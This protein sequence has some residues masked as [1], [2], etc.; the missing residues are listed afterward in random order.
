MQ[1]FVHARIYPG[2]DDDL[3]GWLEDQP[4]GGRSEAIR[5]LMRDGMKMRQLETNLARM[6]RDAVTET[7]ANLP[8]ASEPLGSTASG[9]EAE[10]TFGDQLDQLLGR[11][12]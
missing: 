5:A 9:S 8:A 7:L 2:R 6:I 11:F 10:E 4:T 1:Q 3:I 12:G